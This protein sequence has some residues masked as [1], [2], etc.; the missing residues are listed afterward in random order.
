MTEYMTALNR[1]RRCGSDCSGDAIF[2]N[3]IYNPWEK[4][5]EGFWLCPECQ[6]AYAHRVVRFLNEYDCTGP[7][8]G[9]KE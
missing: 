8:G 7:Y 3:S 9:T 2:C 1:C 5:T 6:N 4:I